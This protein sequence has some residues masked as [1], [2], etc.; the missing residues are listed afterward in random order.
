MNW[1]R[2]RPTTPGLYH[3]RWSA[4]GTIV[5]VGIAALPQSPNQ[6][7]S[8]FE[9]DWHMMHGMDYTGSF[10]GLRLP[11]EDWKRIEWWS[12]PIHPPD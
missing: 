1:T 12:K 10:A 6:L 5:Y 11:I 8:V 7:S 2:E 9:L 4:P 3:W